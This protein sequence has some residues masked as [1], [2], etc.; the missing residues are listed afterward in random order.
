MGEE[1]DSHGSRTTGEK[2]CVHVRIRPRFEGTGVSSLLGTG[3]GEW[4]SFA[5]DAAAEPA[6]DGCPPLTGRDLDGEEKY[7]WFALTKGETVE[8]V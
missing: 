4:R 3:A 5:G 7:K 2:S 6:G 1:V 8:M